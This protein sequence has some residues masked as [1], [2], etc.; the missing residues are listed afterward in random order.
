M[1][2]LDRSLA[3][4]EFDLK[5]IVLKANE[6]FCR[7]LGYAASEI[8]GQH[9]RLFV[10]DEMARSAEYAEFWRQLGE[11]QFVSRAFKRFAKG[12]REIYIQGSYNPVKTKGG[13]VY[14]VVKVASD[15]TAETV[16]AMADAGKIAAI[17]RAQAVIEFTPEGNI[18]TA[19]ENFLG[20]LGYRVD[21]IVGRH[22]RIFVDAATSQSSAYEDFWQ[23]LRRGEFQADEFKRIGKGGKEV[24]IQASYNPIFDDE[25]R[26]SRVV[27][28]ATD[29]TS[30]VTAV[31]VLSEGLTELAGGNLTRRIDQT[32]IPAFENTR[33]SF[34]TSLET[35]Q[36]AMRAVSHKANGILSNADQIRKEAD[37]LSHRTAEQAAALEQSSAALAELTGSVREAAQGADDIGQLV[38]RT[39]GEA[40]RSGIVV[41]KAIEAMGEIEGSSD[42]IGRIIG[43]IDEIAFQT[44]LLALNAGVEAARAGEA[45]RGFAV[46]A[47]EVRGLA[48]RSAEAAKEIKT[49]ISA[50]SN[51][52]KGGVELVGATG[53]ALDDI[54]SKVAEIDNHVT[55]MVASARSQSVG[56]NEISIAI[57]TLDQGTQQNAA[58]VEEATSAAN[59]MASEADALNT[60]LGQFTIEPEQ[61]R[62][63]APSPARALNDRLQQAYPRTGTYG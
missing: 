63:P 4:I 61:R 22:H 46:V 44:N 27:K 7:T 53:R 19:N 43:V 54:I 45:G 10:G 56:L 59:E 2:A 9:H 34:N 41:S 11:G 8:V 42:K 58:M 13:K 37:H 50:S 31:R 29:V 14:K 33:Q 21:E 40:E 12:N 18:L 39:K 17:S 28:F 25:K 49:L 62:G 55:R 3:V 57:G 32:F 51:Q 16:S 48:Q 60:L 52:V 35:L 47:Q 38:A 30:R 20:A 6:N 24:F 5:G 26:V 1:A 36:A 15:I 23:K